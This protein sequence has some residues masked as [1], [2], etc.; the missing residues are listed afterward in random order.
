[1]PVSQ[2]VEQ[3]IFYNAHLAMLPCAWQATDVCITAVEKYPADMEKCTQVG[4]GVSCVACAPRAF[5]VKSKDTVLWTLSTH[6]SHDL[7]NSL[8]L[9]GFV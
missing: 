5:K 4:R 2:P 3:L 9:N 1:V 6:I 7:Q 8:T